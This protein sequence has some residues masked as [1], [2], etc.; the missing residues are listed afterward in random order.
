MGSSVLGMGV[1]SPVHWLIL[2]FG[3]GGFG[4][5]VG[6]PPL[7]ED[8]MMAN[9]APAECLAYLSSAGMATPDAKS[10]NQ[11]EQLLAEPEV[12]QMA[13]EIERAIRAGLK[14]SARRGLPPGVTS[15]DLADVAKLLLTRPLAVYVS[16]FQMQRGGPA[17]R[18]GIAVD[19]GDD[20]A[21]VK[22]T[23]EQLL[24]VV[25]PQLVK[26]IDVSG[27]KWTSFKTNPDV[28]LVFGFHGKY[29]IATV[30]EGEIEALLKRATGT[31]PAWLAKL[32]QDLPVERLSTV[33][34]FDL[35][36]IEKL[37][38]PMAGLDVARVLKALGLENVTALASVTGL[39]QKGCLNKTLLSIDGEPSGILA[40]TD[41]KPLTAA[42]L[43]PIPHDATFAVAFRLNPEKVFDTILDI[44]EKIEPRSKQDMDRS[45]AA[46]RSELGLALRDDIL[47]PLGDTWRLFDSPSEGG[48]FTGLTLVVSLNDPQRAATTNATLAK[49]IQTQ[50]A[51]R[52]KRLRSQAGDYQGSMAWRYMSRER[53]EVV[54]FGGH[55]INAYNSGFGSPFAPAWCV[56]DKELIVSLHPQS[57]KA[58]LSRPADF[59]SLAQAPEV[60]PLLQGDAGPV[61]LLYGNSQR[62][63]DVLY[64]M[65]LSTLPHAIWELQ[66]SGIALSPALL[67]SA[68]AIRSHLAPTVIAVRR[69]K[70]GIE[71]VEQRSI[72]GPSLGAAV[73][74][75]A[76]VMLPAIQSSRAA[77]RRVQSINQL[78]QIGLAMHNYGT[79]NRKLPPAYTADK[80][81][82][83]LLS[84]RV[85]ILPY[86]EGGDLYKQFHLDEPWDSE[87]N[88]KLISRMP[89]AYKSPT[90][91]VSGQWKT[92]Y[93]TVRGKHTIFSGED[94]AT[95]ASVHDGLSYTIMTVEVS[96]A[97]A[98]FWTK[99]D[100]F[101]YGEENPLKGLVGLQP[102]G[103]IAG[104]GDGSVRFIRSSINPKTLNALFTRDGGEFIDPSEIDR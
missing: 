48:A 45:V 9:V 93:L 25:P 104:M 94:G 8:P 62:V 16:S 100:D 87:H 32:R 35:K 7:P 26:E 50:L 103:F 66:R 19:C 69:T 59:Q 39:D 79:A 73:P 75:G 49:V 76:A 1:F 77:A 80:E 12:R 89:A 72:P 30:G 44:S 43:A 63:F 27:E 36:A 56:T 95:F 46:I 6:V 88:K 83:P 13:A 97:K 86:V 78:K 98:V 18:G 14:Q 71:I 70:A 28:G 2:F 81:G 53:L 17:V 67:P 58:Y 38:L 57:I 22:T 10:G 82:K 34:Y 99:P 37:V 29:F 102:G 65:L 47:K 33:T 96:D 21:K 91:T 24:K 31:P 41:V 23:I 5:P 90:S 85:M 54:K 11:T 42:D 3:V 68:R 84:W 101:E 92:N 40:L 4:L 20:G 52:E 60:A 15:D 61:K 74:I 51:E 64:P 55:E